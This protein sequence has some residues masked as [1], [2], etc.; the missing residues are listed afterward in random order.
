MLA[1][2]I[3]MAFTSTLL[4]QQIPD[5]D[6]SPAQLIDTL[7]VTGRSADLIGI[8]ATASEGHVGAADLRL[9]PITR[10]GEL[11][12]TVPGLIV[13]QALGRRQVPRRPDIPPAAVV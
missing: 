5:R 9:R 8:A 1:T 7:T 3:A 10:E 13:T 4:A 6:S 11:L 12:E 2:V